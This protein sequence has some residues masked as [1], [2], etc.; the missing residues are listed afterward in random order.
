MAR[1]DIFV[2]ARKARHFVTARKARH[3]VTA[4]KARK[5][6]LKKKSNPNWKSSKKI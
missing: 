4:W 2:T 3:L 6:H 1:L 5:V